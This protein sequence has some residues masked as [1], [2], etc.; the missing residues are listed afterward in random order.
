MAEAPDGPLRRSEQSFGSEMRAKEAKLAPS[1][2][3]VRLR[4][5]TGLDL[6]D[7]VD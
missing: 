2:R 3:E 4:V 5:D 1:L 7:G 6:V